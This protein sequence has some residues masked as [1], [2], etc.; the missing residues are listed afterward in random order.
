MSW[1][2]DQSR[3]G[4]TQRLVLLAIADCA[5]DRGTDAYPA[6]STLAKKTGLSERGVRKAIND[7]QS[8]GELEVDYKAGPKGC[9]R[10]RVLMPDLAPHAGSDPAPRATLDPELSAGYP[11]HGAG[12]EGTRHDVHSAPRAGSSRHHVPGTRHETTGDP[13][14]GAPE[15]S[16]NHPP[17]EPSLEPSLSGALFEPQTKPPRKTATK[18]GADPAFDAF[19]AAYPRKIS[20]GHARKA[21]TTATATGTDPAEIITATEA[22]A[23]RCARNR[24]EER[25]IPHP[26]T[27]LN[28]E[29]WGD[30]PETDR[31][32]AS[33]NGYRPFRNPTDSSAYEGEL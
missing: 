28:G 19:W 3:S 1:V 18:P 25:F 8:I 23:A 10:Y 30:Q 7:L 27:W 31:V 16:L 12:L 22:H 11:E 15:P 13:A 5:N 14:P 33:T 2:W 6:A 29:R 32:G 24:T 17:T 4:P 20:K 26:A 9:N 21:W